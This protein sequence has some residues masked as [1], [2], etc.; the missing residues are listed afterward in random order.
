MRCACHI[1]VVAFCLITALS[2][3]SCALLAAQDGDLNYTPDDI[4]STPAENFLEWM[5]NPEPGYQ[6]FAAMNALAKKAKLSDQK[7]RWNILS[8][9]TSA[10]YDTTRSINQRFQCCYVISLSGDEAW[11]PNLAYVLLKDLSPT[12]RSVAA[13]ALGS[14]RHNTAARN[15]LTQAS[16]Q[17]TDKNALEVINRCLAEGDAEYTS[18]QIKSTSVETFLERIEKPEPGYQKFSAMRALGRKAKESD[19]NARWSIISRAISVINDTSRTVNLRFQCC[20]V[21]SISGDERGVPCLIDI[22]NKDPLF[23]MR[24][25]AAEAL[26]TYKTSSEAR[27]ALVQASSKETNQSVLDVINRV[28]GKTNSTD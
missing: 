24:T 22:L 12:M 27:N 3:S 8:L 6:R 21:I 13:E 7:N 25:V 17:E 26:G 19:S 1:V 28:L 11:V 16:R 20:Y 18:E 23:N 4:Q 10:M 2:S 9:V 14:F 15:A 5:A